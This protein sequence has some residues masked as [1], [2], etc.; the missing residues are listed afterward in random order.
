MTTH[1]AGTRLD[2]LYRRFPEPL[3]ARVARYRWVTPDRVS[4]AAFVAGGVV[5]PL[6]VFRTR[7][8]SAGVAFA[9]SDLL[10]YLDGDVARA[11]DTTSAQ[12]DILDGILDRYTDLLCVGAMTMAAA[13][14][15]DGQRRT[16]AAFIGAPSA[17]VA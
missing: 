17:G 10:D 14:G 15:F 6:L 2:Q 7:L 16:P 11:Q 4:S 9:L 3:A 5:A 8:R 12:G 13:G 1:D